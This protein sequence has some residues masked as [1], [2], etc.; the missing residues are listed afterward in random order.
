MSPVQKKLRGI[1][2]MRLPSEV[3]LL[4]IR[5]FL[6]ALVQFQLSQTSN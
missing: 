6:L 4:V 3:F 2:G 1:E 5:D